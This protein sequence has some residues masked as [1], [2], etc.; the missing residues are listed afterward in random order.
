MAYLLDSSDTIAK[1]ELKND[2]NRLDCQRMKQD[3]QFNPVDNW[4]RSTNKTAEERRKGSK[5]RVDKEPR[6]RMRLEPLSDS[7]SANG[8]RAKRKEKPKLIGKYKVKIKR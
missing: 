4:P 3:S 5:N 7:S 2:G 8:P 1:M 6:K